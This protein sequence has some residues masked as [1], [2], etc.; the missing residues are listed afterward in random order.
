MDADVVH[1]ES[2]ANDFEKA[3]EILRA[4]ARQRNPIWMRSIVTR[5]VG[6]DVCNL[7]NDVRRYESTGQTRDNTWANSKDATAVR[8]MKNTMGYVR[9][10]KP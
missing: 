6:R 1:L 10:Q 4:Q 2:L 3:A 5:G 8:R 7:V 9:T